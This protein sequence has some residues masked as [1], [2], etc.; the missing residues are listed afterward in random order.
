V[1]TRPSPVV[2]LVVVALA[3]LVACWVLLISAIETRPWI[4]D[5]LSV[6]ADAGCG[7]CLAP[8]T[9]DLCGACE[10]IAT[11]AARHLAADFPGHPAIDRITYHLEGPYPGEGP[12]GETALRTKTGTSIV[13]VVTFTDGT[14]DAVSVSCGVGGCR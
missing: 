12:H 3:L 4:V 10:S 1:T 8:N 6:G 2:G 14:V 13:A 11:I 9:S 5:G 7:A